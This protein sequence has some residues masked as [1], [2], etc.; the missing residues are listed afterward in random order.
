ML[1]LPKNLEALG[2]IAAKVPHHRY[3]TQC[4]RVESPSVEYPSDSTYTVA[5][6]DGGRAVF[7]QGTHDG[8]DYPVVQALASAPNGQTV[9]LVRREDWQAAFKAVPRTPHFKHDTS[10]VAVVM[11][12]GIATLATTD[13]TNESVRISEVEPSSKFPNMRDVIPH[14]K[15][16]A[17]IT[18]DAAK[19]AELLNVVSR[20]SD[21]MATIEIYAAD[22]PLAIRAKAKTQETTAV[23]VPLAHQPHQ[24]AAPVA[25]APVASAD[26]PAPPAASQAPAPRP[27]RKPKLAAPVAPAL[28]PIPAPP[29]AFAAPTCK[30]YAQHLTDAGW[31]CRDCGTVLS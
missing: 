29:V 8:T 17:S 30:H 13:G 15:P 25:A 21:G 3:A 1:L 2:I 9:A 31:T 12:K 19:L 5:A 23:M 6:C 14:G 10:R 16:L 24:F 26:V 4:V 27:K 11:G 20:L 22:K 28:E 18:M 7:V